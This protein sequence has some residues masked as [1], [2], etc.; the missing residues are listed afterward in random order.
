MFDIKQYLNYPKREVQIKQSDYGKPAFWGYFEK[1]KT[2]TKYIKQNLSEPGI[3][4]SFYRRSGYGHR[5]PFYN[6]KRTGTKAYAK[7]YHKAAIDGTGGYGARP[8][9]TTVPRTRGWAGTSGEMK[10]FDTQVDSDAIVSAA[11]WANAEMDPATFL[12][13]CVPVKGTGIS[14]RVGR[15]IKVSKI[16]IRGSVTCDSQLNRILPLEEFILRIAVVQDT[17]TNA[18]QLN[19]E[20]VYDGGATPMLAV[21]AY[22]SLD[23]LGRFK[24]LRNSYEKLEQPAMTWDGTNELMNAIN[25]TFK[26]NINFKNPVEVHFNETNGGTIADIVDNSFHVIAMVSD[27]IDP[28]PLLNYQCRVCYKDM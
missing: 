22:Q 23:N 21:A 14:N 17:Q 7:K 25:H 6:R 10:Y 27:A 4:M 16:K 19:A 2:Q 18:A 15:R 9:F 28:S 5:A 13:L 8:G 26:F 11:T 24:V 20:D 3:P 1:P 12:T